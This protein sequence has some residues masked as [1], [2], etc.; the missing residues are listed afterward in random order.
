ME[1]L[2]LSSVA[3]SVLE[4]NIARQAPVNV[5]RDPRVGKRGWDRGEP[6]VAVKATWGAMNRA[7]TRHEA[8]IG[9]AA[10]V[11]NRWQHLTTGTSHWCE[12]RTATLHTKKTE[13]ASA[14]S[15]ASIAYAWKA[16]TLAASIKVRA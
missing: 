13:L 16:L 9:V 10:V 8:A 6:P 4:Q 2:A 14:V 12:R 1:R 11:V 3:G 15:I 5:E 7:F